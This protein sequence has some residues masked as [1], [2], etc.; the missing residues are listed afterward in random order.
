MDERVKAIIS[1][2]AVLI[3]NGVSFWGISLDVNELTNALFA[4]AM[5]VSTVWGIWKNHNFTVAAQ[6]GQLVT[7]R[8]KNE[9]RA[10]ELKD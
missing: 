9:Q 3:V 1:A 2:A 6:Q 10:I 8:I 7:N 4:I 5:L